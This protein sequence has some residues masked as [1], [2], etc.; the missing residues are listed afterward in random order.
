MARYI[1]ADALKLDID[2]SKGASVLDMALAVIKSVKDAPTA[3]VVPRSE[4]EKLQN[5]LVIWKQ[6]RFNLYQK[7]ECYEMARQTVAR[8][9][10]AEIE[11]EIANLD[12]DRDETRMIAIEGIIANAK[13]KYTEG[14][15]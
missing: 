13:K 9:I 4:V 11:F 12:F 2:L 3:D 14:K 15:K 1:D 7:L 8:E 5:D 6:N 10:F